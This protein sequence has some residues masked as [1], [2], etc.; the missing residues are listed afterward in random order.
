M[1]ELLWRTCDACAEHGVCVIDDG[2]AYV[3]DRCVG[4]HERAIDAAAEA[5]Y[6]LR[7]RRSPNTS[8]PPWPSYFQSGR[9]EMR[10]QA[11]VAVTAYDEF[12]ANDRAAA[13]TREPT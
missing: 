2:G 9:D 7:Y 3:C 11:R 4:F 1:A 8:P 6:D 5:L 13:S 12:Y 10:E